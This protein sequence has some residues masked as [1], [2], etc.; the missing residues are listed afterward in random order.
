MGNSLMKM[1]KT[2]YKWWSKFLTFFGDIKV[3]SYPLWLVYDP[4]DFQVGGKKVLDIIKTLKP[5]DIILRGYNKYL[6]GKFI[7]SKTKFSH[8]AVYIGEGKIIHA[9]A[10][11]VSLTNVIDFT[12]CDRIAIF[13]PINGQ[14]EAIKRA[15]EFLGTKVPYDFGFERGVSALYCFELCGECY[16]ELDIPH[17]TVKKFFGLVKRNNVY[18]ADSFFNSPDLKCVFNYNP[19]L[20]IDYSEVQY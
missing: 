6:D 4:D 8:G 16:K 13:R 2:I 20:G 3:F 11:G 14:D 5:G 18:L 17:Y 12:R 9:V 1:P 19:A 15:K 7:P 10:E